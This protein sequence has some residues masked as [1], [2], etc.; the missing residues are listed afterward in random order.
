MPSVSSPISVCLP[1]CKLTRYRLLVALCRAQAY[2][3]ELEAI[4]KRERELRR[5]EVKRERELR[6]ECE[7]R[8]KE[9]EA[10]E[11]R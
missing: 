3:R 4:E 5:E 11:R 6:A 10:T 9:E 8:R 7:R 2:R 1:V